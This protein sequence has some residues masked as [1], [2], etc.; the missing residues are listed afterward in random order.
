MVKLKKRDKM[1]KQCIKCKHRDIDT[2]VTPCLN[3]KYNPFNTDSFEFIIISITQHD[4]N[5]MLLMISILV[6]GLGM[7]AGAIIGWG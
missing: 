4:L 5:L 6:F 1:K 2:A 3:C 7:I